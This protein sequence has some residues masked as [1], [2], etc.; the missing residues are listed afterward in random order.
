ML[1]RK[2]SSRVEA[3]PMTDFG[4][5]ETL[6]DSADIF[7]INK[8]VSVCCCI[9]V[10]FMPDIWMLFKSHLLMYFPWNLVLKIW[11]EYSNSWTSKNVIKYH[12]TVCHYFFLCPLPAVGALLAAGLCHHQCHLCVYEHPQDVWALPSIAVC[13][14]HAGHAAHVP[15]HRRD[16]R[17]DAHQRNHQGSYWQSFM[18]TRSTKWRYNKIKRHL[19]KFSFH[20]TEIFSNKILTQEIDTSN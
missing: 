20:N 8:P 11:Q 10:P 4:P 18:I 13:D 16:D 5:D 15:L 2:Q 19:H 17:Q 1:K 6:A 14:V 12:S 3:Q 9:S 7:W